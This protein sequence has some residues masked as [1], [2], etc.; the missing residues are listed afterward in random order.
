MM[1][2]ARATA[3]GDATASVGRRGIWVLWCG[4]RSGG[5]PRG[6][7]RANRGGGRFRSPPRK[8]PGPVRGRGATAAERRAEASRG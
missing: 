2:M 6:G 3:P 4:M 1:R 7:S 5:T 8:R